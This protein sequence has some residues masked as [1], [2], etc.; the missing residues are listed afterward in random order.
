MAVF[1]SG[2]TAVVIIGGLSLGLLTFFTA[3]PDDIQNLVALACAGGGWLALIRHFSLTKPALVIDEHGIVDQA[4]AYEVGR[5]PWSEIRGAEIVW[6]SGP[7][8]SSKVLAIAVRDLAPFRARVGIIGRTMMRLEQW[9]FGSGSVI[10]IHQ[11]ALRTPVEEVL[12]SLQQHWRLAPRSGRAAAPART[13][14]R[15]TR[16]TG[17]DPHAPDPADRRAH[18]LTVSV[19]LLLSLALYGL[20]AW[21]FPTT[22]F[23]IVGALLAVALVL[24]GAHHLRLWMLSKLA[25]FVC[26][27]LGALLVWSAGVQGVPAM[28]TQLL[29]A[30]GAEVAVIGTKQ[31][32][33]NRR[34]F[35]EYQLSLIGYQS[36]QKE[37]LCV[38][39][40]LWSQ[41]VVGQRVEIVIRKDVLGTRIFDI[42]LLP[43]R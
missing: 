17:P 26:V 7:R 9:G 8:G 14:A 6:R 41:V 1:V 42:R 13:A 25:F 10:D 24:A 4:S 31:R 16:P 37:T 35:C 18:G 21:Y 29:G 28:V 38:K 43:K 30:R 2:L 34:V 12:S 40:A 19:V 5:I 27:P 39:R 23:A 36:V 32:T 22:T 20:Y 11:S 33:A 15:P 3:F